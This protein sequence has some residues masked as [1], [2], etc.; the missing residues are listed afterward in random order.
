MLADPSAQALSMTG[1]LT[2]SQFW[3]DGFAAVGIWFD[4]SAVQ[5]L[6]GS[7]PQLFANSEMSNWPVALTPPPLKS[8]KKSPAGEF[9]VV[10]EAPICFQVEI[11]CSSSEAR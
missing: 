11:S 10:T 4:A 9:L 6:L 1:S 3:P 7:G 8:L 5:K 2:R